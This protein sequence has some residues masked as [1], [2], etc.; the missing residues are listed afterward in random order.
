VSKAKIHPSAVV[1]EGVVLGEGTTVGALAVIEDGVVM[2]AGNVIW[3]QAFVGRG[4]TLGDQNQ[5]HP[6]AIVGHAPQDL[7]FDEATETFTKIGSR[8]AF[9]DLCQ[10]HRATKEG[11]ATTV[12]DDNM[13]MALSHVA[14]DCVIG[15]NVILVNQ[16]CLAGHC[17][18]EDRALLSG[19]VGLHQFVR[20]G[21]L[22]MVTSHSATNK[23]LPPFFM[24]GGRPATAYGV[25]RVGMRRAGVSREVLREIKESYKILYRTQGQTISDA[26][27]QIEEKYASD[28]V[29]ELVAFIRNSKRG[30]PF[31]GKHVADNIED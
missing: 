7:S 19:Y 26:L 16:V 17:V 24:W 25:N 31:G 2:G 13:I 8:N 29:K 28:E 20:I 1:G 30:I 22:A 6:G 4:T 12:G 15:N 3:P 18:I 27:A 9:R 14:H 5:V 11:A 10:V 21:R 23:D